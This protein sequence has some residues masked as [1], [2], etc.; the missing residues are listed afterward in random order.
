MDIKII[1][2]IE[3]FAG[4]GGM[5]LGLQQ[6]KL[7]SS[8]LALDVNHHCINTLRSNARQHF[9]ELL[10]I[11]T[12]LL[13]N[14]DKPFTQ[15]RCW[16]LSAGFPCQP[17]SV[18]NR[19]KHRPNASLDLRGVQSV[20]THVTHCQPKLIILENVPAFTD[21]DNGNTFKWLM[22]SLRSRGYVTAHEVVNMVN[23]QV[24]QTRKRLIIVAWL[25]TEFP[26]LFKIGQPL[27]PTTAPILTLRDTLEGVPPS[28]G[29]KLSPKTADIYS[30]VSPGTCYNK[31]GQRYRRLAW[32]EPSPTIVTT[33]SGQGAVCH[34]DELRR[35]T[36]R[37]AARIQTFP[38]SYAFTGCM[39]QQY[40]Q[41][42]NAVPPKYM[43]QL[44]QV[45]LRQ[46]AT[47]R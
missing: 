34:P 1:E 27:V 7:V 36:V 43:E 2:H 18:A 23:H 31:E 41:I 16:L 4:A 13:A 35:L 26:P 21:A 11:Q 42:G 10:P 22:S 28:I 6:S 12:D 29:A 20:L 39:S 17:F 9:G 45:L 37:E 24:P 5:A 32:D 8:T 15:E 46:L 33:S 40:K 30:A 44:G 3:L 19:G 38:D 47:Q 14:P 25:S